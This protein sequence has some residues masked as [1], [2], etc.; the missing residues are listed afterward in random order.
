MM[1]EEYS[2]NY[3]EETEHVIYDIPELSEKIIKIIDLHKIPKNINKLILLK[4]T[5]E[6]VIFDE[7]E[8]E[9]I[10]LKDNFITDDIFININ[11][12]ILNLTN[13]F[14]GTISSIE[15]INCKIGK[16]ILSNNCLSSVIFK[17]TYVST[18]E[19]EDCC[20]K[21]LISLPECLEYLYLAKN[22]IK[23]ICTQFNNLKIIDLEHN[24]IEEIIFELPNTL[25]RLNLSNNNIL[26]ELDL[27]LPKN[28][29]YFDISNN[30]I[31][32]VKNITLNEKLKYLD[33]SSNKLNN[34]NEY[35]DMFKNIENIDIDDNEC[36][37]D[38]DSDSSMHLITYFNSDN[39]NDNDNNY[40]DDLYGNQTV[41]FE[42][43]NRIIREPNNIKKISNNDDFN[44]YYC[45]ENFNRNNN[46]NKSNLLNL[47][48]FNNINKEE[49]K[50]IN[51]EKVKIELRWH[52]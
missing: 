17:N 30:Q 32:N 24:C 37:D 43:N 19:M 2:N 27:I 14:D 33:M 13:A 34:I 50:K 22:E 35:I 40:D 1:S 31:T 9:E 45:F 8:W 52:D 47:D 38:S 10:N 25:E 51:T 5:I 4:K 18:Y 23:K 49:N 39:D 15:F 16:L 48:I 6:N 28:L 12:K 11:T 29:K 3:T 46:R 26:G 7:R 20:L 42:E 21:E 36:C 44:D 41:N